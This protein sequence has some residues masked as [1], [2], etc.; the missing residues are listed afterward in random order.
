MIR[1][2]VTALLLVILLTIN[3]NAVNATRRSSFHDEDQPIATP[4]QEPTSTPAQPPTQTP[5]STKI[6]ILTTI[7]LNDA[8]I[9]DSPNAANTATAV[10]TSII[11]RPAR[12]KVDSQIIFPVRAFVFLIILALLGYLAYEYRNFKKLQN[13]TQKKRSR[14]KKK[15]V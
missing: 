6:P 9:T 11:K 15:S 7:P 5:T 10:P 3:L 1:R 13:A 2:F 8:F 14:T 4:T 12:T